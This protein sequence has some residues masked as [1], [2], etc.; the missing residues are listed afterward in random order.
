MQA[1]SCR[2]SPSP[3]PSF[4]R[5]SVGAHRPPDAY[6]WWLATAA[7]QVGDHPNP[8]GLSFTEPTIIAGGT[9]AGTTTIFVTSTQS[10][11]LVEYR[12]LGAPRT[13]SGRS[14]PPH[15]PPHLDPR[16]CGGTGGSAG[17]GVGGDGQAGSA[18]RRGFPDQ[19]LEAAE[20]VSP[21]QRL[22]SGTIGIWIPLQQFDDIGL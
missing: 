20:P 16:L 1:T 3:W 5:G 2:G 4:F 10:S 17:K 11:G 19:R 14:F 21:A 9:V 18:R 12:T 6:P 15:E 22:D 7:I 13:G 8:T